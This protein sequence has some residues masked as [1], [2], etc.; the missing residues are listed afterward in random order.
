M[1]ILN[2]QINIQA[3]PEKVWDILWDKESYKNWASVFHE[4]T[5]YSGDLTEGEEVL[6]LVPEGHGMFSE[7]KKVRRFD[8]VTFLHLGEVE[9]FQKGEII[10]ENA[11]ESYFLE[12]TESGC[13]LKAALNCE[14]EYVDQMNKMFPAA[15]QKVKELAEV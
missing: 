9:N 15:L 7:V 14:D 11:Y 12:E 10:Y 1:Q 6:F 4:G 8:E 3:S 2:Y 13:L 5:F